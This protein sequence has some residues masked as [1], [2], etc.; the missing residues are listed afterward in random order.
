[1]SFRRAS[2]FAVGLAALS[3]PAMASSVTFFQFQGDPDLFS[4]PKEL[5]YDSTTGLSAGPG[6][7]GTATPSN[8]SGTTYISTIFGPIPIP[9]VFSPG[10]TGI[11]T[12]GLPGVPESPP[13]IG[14][15]SQTSFNI[16][17]DLTMVLTGFT[18]V[19]NATVGATTITQQL[20]SGSFMII[21]PAFG[22]PLLSGTV[23]DVMITENKVGQGSNASVLSGVVHY[24]SSLLE[25]DF[26]AAGLS[27]T[28]SFSFALTGLGRNVFG[29]TTVGNETHLAS[30]SGDATGSFD[31]MPLTAVPSPAVAGGGFALLGLMVAGRLRKQSGLAI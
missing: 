25:Q 6:A 14:F 16:L 13:G 10:L 15:P 5:V 26:A 19:G 12:G 1:M 20:S 8:L 21:H 23:S 30:F 11:I 28:G 22:I 7:M 18:P 31:V 9:G 17:T 29:T 24:D 3:A 4:N 27:D 2:L